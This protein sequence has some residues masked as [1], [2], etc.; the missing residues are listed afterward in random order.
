MSTPQ[1]IIVK[2]KSAKAAF[3]K[4]REASAY[5]VIKAFIESDPNIT[6]IGTRGYTPSFNDGDPCYHYGSPV[7]NEYDEDG[8]Y[9]GNDEEDD[10]VIVEHKSW[11]NDVDRIID[12][13]AQAKYDTNFCVIF[14]LSDSGEVVETYEEYY[15]GY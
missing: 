14:K 2:Y 7:I 6:S 9:V 3:E 13:Y 4:Q 1:E 5:E 11:H 12:E 10:E 8:C 15:A